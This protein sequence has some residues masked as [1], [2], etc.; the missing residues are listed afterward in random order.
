[1]EKFKTFYEI[2]YS[3]VRKI[4]YDHVS[5]F[6]GHAALFMLMA[7]FPMLMFIMSMLK[8]LP[9]DWSDALENLLVMMPAG[10]TPFLKQIL[11]EAY[12]ESTTVA[13]R[14]AT[15]IVML[16]CAA[17]GVYAV[18]VGMNAV[19]GI[20]EERNTLLVYLIS[21]VYVIGLF[22]M[23][24]LMLVL[25]VLGNRLF[26]T[27]IQFFPWLGG[28]HAIFRYG[29]YLCMFA[30]LLL[31]FLTLYMTMPNRKSKIRYELPGT[32]FTAV[33][34]LI[35][36]WAFSFYIEN[37]G[38]Y[39]ITYGSLATIVVFIVWLYGT[40]NIIFIGGEINV[41]LRVFMEYG[42][43]YRRA[44]EFFDDEYHGDLFKGNALEHLDTLKK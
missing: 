20:R 24:G 18:V 10:F 1:M 27:L 9:I 36:S 19:Y 39:S 35:F 4:K 17:R 38:N 23:I 33:V 22:V 32:F 44:Y 26:S 42:Y 14:Y 3:F 40:M 43:N 13:L 8:Y 11:E 12:T 29:K 2:A 6:A 30:V 25:I 37:F 21:A 34:W 7:L 28:F 15:M 5:S 16:Y 41:V 31:F